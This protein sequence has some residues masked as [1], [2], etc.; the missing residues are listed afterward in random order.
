MTNY[1]GL[2]NLN[3]ATS[4]KKNIVTL[5]ITMDDTLL[6]QVLK[7]LASLGNVSFCKITIMR[8]YTSKQIVEI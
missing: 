7:S 2:T 5:N 1:K 6:M 4:I 8:I 3:I